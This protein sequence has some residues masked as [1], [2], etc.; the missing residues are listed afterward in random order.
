MIEVKVELFFP[1][2]QSDNLEEHQKDSIEIFFDYVY[3]TY[4]E[5]E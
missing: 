5:I 3:I 2:F 1:L 4:L